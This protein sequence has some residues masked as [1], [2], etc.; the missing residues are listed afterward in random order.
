MILD[1]A[2]IA[3][4]DSDRQSVEEERGAVRGGGEFGHDRYMEESSG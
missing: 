2:P 1:L 4:R 3:E